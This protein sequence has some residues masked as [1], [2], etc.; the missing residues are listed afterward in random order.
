MVELGNKEENKEA[1]GERQRVGESTERVNSP[2]ESANR[3]SEYI[4]KLR[5]IVAMEK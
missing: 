4:F 3:E 5:A 1:E 2:I